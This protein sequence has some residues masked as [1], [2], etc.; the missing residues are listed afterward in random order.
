MAVKNLKMSVQHLKM[1]VQN[2]M[3][4]HYVC[5]LLNPYF[6]LFIHFEFAFVWFEEAHEEAKPS[7]SKL[8][9]Q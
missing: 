3:Y 1:S 9:G 4:G 6:K 8:F 5:T 2:I 7:N